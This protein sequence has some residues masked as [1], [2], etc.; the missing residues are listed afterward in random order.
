MAVG[1]AWLPASEASVKVARAKKIARWWVSA[2]AS[3]IPGFAGAVFHGSVNWL[4]DDA[5][6]PGTSDLDV[7]VVLDGQAPSSKLGKFLHRD[8][9]L[10]VSFLSSDELRSPEQ[11]LGSSHLAGSFHTASVILDPSGALSALQAKVAKEYAKRRWVL[12]RCAHAREKILTGFPLRTGDPFPDQVNAWLFPAGITTHI[13]LLA[14]LRNPTV[15]TRYLAVRRMLAEY[16]HLAR[17]ELLLNLLGASRMTQARASQHLAALEAAFDAAKAV[18]KTPFFFAGDLSDL[19]R[20]VTIDGSRELIAGGDQREA[21]FWMVAT[22]TRCQQVFHFDA[23][24][25]EERFGPG[26]RALLAD[27]GINSY[28][29]LQRR[30]GEVEQSLPRAWDLAE[31]VIAA[32]PDIHD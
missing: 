9:L 10:D 18:V 22:A 6:L 8:V 32:N 20:P 12:R 19:A 5:E 7:M 15:R 1:G 23:P 30:R 27:L 24:H 21:I 29:D 13:L 31:A 26:Y 16:G 14:G 17:Y 4:S 3:Q 25:L 2:E 11:V 28:D